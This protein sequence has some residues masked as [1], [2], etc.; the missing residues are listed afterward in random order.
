[1]HSKF[2]A[3]QRGR[4]KGI[5]RTWPECF[6]QIKGY[7]HAEYKNFTNITDALDYLKWN[8]AEK[9]EFTNSDSNSNYISASEEN[10][11][12]EKAIKA[13]KAFSKTIKKND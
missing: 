6:K 9:L 3:V 10:K 5:Y 8:N 13:I 11:R 1:M 2:Y 4:V 7:P 12:L